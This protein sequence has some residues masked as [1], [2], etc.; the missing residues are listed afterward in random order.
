MT[1]QPNQSSLLTRT[2]IALVLFTAAGA[3]RPALAQ[4]SGGVIAP[5]L[6]PVLKVV[7]VDV[8]H[9]TWTRRPGTN[10]FDA[11]WVGPNGQKVQDV[12]ELRSLTHGVATF[13]RHGNRGTY[14]GTV[15]PDGRS[16]TGTASWYPAGLTWTATIEAP[17]PPMRPP[18]GVAAAGGPAGWGSKILRDFHIGYSVVA[19]RDGGVAVAG[20]GDPGFLVVRL[21]ASG[22]EAWRRAFRWGETLGNTFPAHDVLETA[23]GSIVAVG[24]GQGVVATESSAYVCK[25][26]RDGAMIWERN[27][28]RR[29]DSVSADTVQ[30]LGTG[31]FLVAAAAFNTGAVLV[32]LDRNGAVVRDKLIPRV[33]TSPLVE[34]DNFLPAYVGAWQDPDGSIYVVWTET[35]KREDSDYAREAYVVKLDAAWNEVWRDRLGKETAQFLTAVGIAPHPEGGV[36]VLAQANHSPLFSYDMEHGVATRF[37]PTGARVW[38]RWFGYPHTKDGFPELQPRSIV[39]SADGFILTGFGRGTRGPFN[40]VGWVAGMSHDGTFRWD[41]LFGRAQ[42]ITSYA[43][44]PLAGGGFCFVGDTFDGARASGYLAHVTAATGKAKDEVVWPDMQLAQK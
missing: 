24:T 14:T 43:G 8:W 9:G 22:K 10:T 27:W 1:A 4:S 28:T 25:L 44:V 3:S 42:R 35:R 34:V 21:D 29:G 37:G 2:A 18:T 23:D 11:A 19:T 38:Q 33:S 15:S 41:R 16:L 17:P 32:H 7:E 26:G 12:L 40:Y 13:Y 5:S 36:V 30:E 31:D 39:P 6:G 20:T